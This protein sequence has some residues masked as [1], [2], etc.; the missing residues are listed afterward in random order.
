ME[1]ND[2]IRKKNPFRV[3]DG[4]FDSLA[5][6]LMNS[7]KEEEE[8]SNTGDRQILETGKSPVND[9]LQ[10]GEMT[11]T[12]PVSEK[13]ERPGEQADRKPAGVIS[14]RP[15]LALAAAII[16]FA[17]LAT[18]MVKLVSADSHSD[19]YVAGTSLYADLAFEEV[20]TYILENEL[21]TTEPAAAELTGEDIP[22][23]A[24]ID[25]LMTED[26]DLN[27]IYELL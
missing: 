4:Y 17:V 23:D 13:D 21:N 22:A 20:D 8:G 11:F 10:G 1:L 6:R 15:F 3:P 25:Y 16:G 14:L 19:A 2:E 18:V 7:I 12:G 5:D 9:P 26:I 27:D 24:I